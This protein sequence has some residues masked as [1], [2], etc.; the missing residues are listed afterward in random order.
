MVYRRRIVRPLPCLKYSGSNALHRQVASGQLNLAWGH[1]TLI[2]LYLE[3][4]AQNTIESS[5]KW[6]DKIMLIV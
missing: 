4:L 1:F 2:D 3:M 5:Q 6:V